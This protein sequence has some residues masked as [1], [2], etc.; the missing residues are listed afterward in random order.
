MLSRGVPYLTGLKLWLG[1]PTTGPATHENV[2]VRRSRRRKTTVTAYR[3][4]DM[5]VISIP[6][7]FTVAQER[8]WVSK[9]LD[10]LAM[11]EAK[12]RPTDDELL[13]RALELNV[14][15]LDG[16]ALPMSVKWAENQER[17]WGS[18]SMPDRSIRL[19]TRLKGLPEWVIDYVLLH[20]LAHILV[21]GHGPDF[22]H[23]LENYPK[24]D[25][26]R[27]FLEGITFAKED[28]GAH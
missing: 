24:T 27:G 20:E 28:S 16:H 13:S 3:D 10:R 14:K 17:R 12:R 1:M 15:Y 18:C 25:R 6:A 19:S 8:E 4:G 23:L 5:T 11:K 7:K 2:E 9:M 22:W 26:A 21:Q